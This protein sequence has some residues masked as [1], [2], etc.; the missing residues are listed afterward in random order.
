LD[1]WYAQRKIGTLPRLRGEDGHRIN[2]RHIID[3]LVR[4]PGAFENYRYKEDLFPTSQFRIAYDMLRAAY[5]TKKANKQYL[6]IL[7]LAARENES[8]VNDALRM[9]INLEVVMDA[10]IV[11]QF[12]DSRTKPP[13]V[14]EVH[15]EVVDLNHYDQLLESPECVCI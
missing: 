12:V 6:K 7:E 10:D 1:I 5:D 13:D 8:L 14:T 11:K 15:V 4:K 9:L 3:W 2:Y